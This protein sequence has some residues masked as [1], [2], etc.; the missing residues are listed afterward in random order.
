MLLHEIPLFTAYFNHFKA[1]IQL[2]TILYSFLF[3]LLKPCIFKIIHF[4]LCQSKVEYIIYSYSYLCKFTRKTFCFTNKWRPMAR[5]F[6]K[7]AVWTLTAHLTTFCVFKQCFLVFW[8]L[9]LILISF[10]FIILSF[11]NNA[12]HTSKERANAIFF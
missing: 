10:S 4:Y 7:S 3:L 12:R 9:K 6:Y 1:H 8:I 5:A 2:H 11:W